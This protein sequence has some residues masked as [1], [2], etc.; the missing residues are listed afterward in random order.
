VTR[1]DKGE[2]LLREKRQ[3]MKGGKR[4]REERRSNERNG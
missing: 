1:S 3:E 4:K 2:R